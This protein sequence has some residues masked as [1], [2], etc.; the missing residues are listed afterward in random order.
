MP[1]DTQNE[2][3]AAVGVAPVPDGTIDSED[4]RQA[5]EVY[6]TVTGTPSTGTRC[7]KMFGDGMTSFTFER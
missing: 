1:V 6:P 7:R 5:A 3:R 4:R 2:R